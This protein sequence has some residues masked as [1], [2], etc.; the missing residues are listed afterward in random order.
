MWIIKTCTN[1]VHNLIFNLGKKSNPYL[2]D[3]KYIHLYRFFFGGGRGVHPIPSTPYDLP[4]AIIK[5]TFQTNSYHTY[6]N[7]WCLLM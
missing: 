3:V 2:K 4:V 5:L 6:H 1:Q 7:H